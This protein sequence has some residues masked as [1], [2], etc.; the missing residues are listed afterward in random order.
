L[1]CVRSK[2][3]GEVRLDANKIDIFGT[4]RADVTG[5]GARGP[6][7]E[8][9]AL[10]K[11][12]ESDKLSLNKVGI[13]RI[14]LLPVDGPASRSHQLEMIPAYAWAILNWTKPKLAQAGGLGLSQATTFC[15][16]LRTRAAKGPHKQAFVFLDSQGA[17]ADELTLKSYGFIVI[18]G[19]HLGRAALEAKIRD[20]AAALRGAE[21]EGTHM[22]D[23]KKGSARRVDKSNRTLR[24]TFSYEGGTVRLVSSQSIE[25]KPP[26]AEPEPIK[27]GQAGFWYELVDADG[28]QLYQRVVHNPIR[29]EDEIYSSEPNAAILRR[30]I[31]VP[32]G[33]FELLVPNVPGAHS[34]IL[35]SSPLEPA[36]SGRPA[37]EL[38]RFRLTDNP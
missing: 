12:V 35:F 21:R 34:V 1:F 16:I 27:E 32:R 20:S 14:A 2:T 22:A 13:G 37:A 4:R 38:A 26:P 15:D 17:I 7:V 36:E 30:K 11:S 33:T 29:V 28:R 31:E 23:D 19:L 5:L 24:L 6:C 3:K 25:M 18:G 8:G 10:P 9:S